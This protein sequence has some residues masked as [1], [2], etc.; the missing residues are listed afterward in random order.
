MKKHIGLLCWPALGLALM[1]VAACDSSPPKDP[2]SYPKTVQTSTLR[3]VEVC[4]QGVVYLTTSHGITVKFE[5]LPGVFQPQP[6]TC[7]QESK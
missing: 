3:L 5:R 4:Y 1:L 2:T 7:P 6:A